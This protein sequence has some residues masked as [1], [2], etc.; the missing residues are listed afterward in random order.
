M[1]N[2]LFV[3]TFLVA[4]G[5][6]AQTVQVRNK[7][8][9]LSPVV[10]WL[11]KKEGERPMPHWKVI[12]IE[13]VLAKEWGGYRV[14]AKVEGTQRQDPIVIQN[15][16][17]TVLRSIA[18]DDATLKAMAEIEMQMLALERQN[19]ELEEQKERTVRDWGNV[20]ELTVAQLKANEEAL[21][22]LQVEYAQREQTLV[23]TSEAKKSKFLAFFTGQ[24]AGSHE[25]WDCGIGAKVLQVGGL[26]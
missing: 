23:S 1:R 25:V 13:K 15:I 11:E 7:T 8:V 10:R 3:M 14:L 21:G 26:P 12:E 18:A 16:P 5:L 19:R 2:A 6:N 9:D 17:A 24:K 22:R 4:W 20:Y